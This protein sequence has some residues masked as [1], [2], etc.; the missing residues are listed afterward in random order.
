M[1]RALGSVAAVVA[2][3]LAIVIGVLA[4]NAN[5]NQQV[6]RPPGGGQAGAPPEVHTVAGFPLHRPPELAT[7]GEGQE[8]GSVSTGGGGRPAVNPP[9]H[10]TFSGGGGHVVAAPTPVRASCGLLGTVVSLLGSLL[11]GGGGC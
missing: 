6:A 5:T 7:G 8:P 11:G 3:A 1:V 9:A 2:A 4:Y 10:A